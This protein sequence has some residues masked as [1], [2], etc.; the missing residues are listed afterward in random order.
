MAEMDKPRSGAGKQEIGFEQKDALELPDVKDIETE[1][2]KDSIVKKMERKQIEEK[3]APKVEA[4][5]K[6][7]PPDVPKLVFGAISK[8]IGCPAFNTDADENR[9]LARHLTTIFGKTDSRITS[10]IIILAI[11]IAK[12]VA[13]KEPIF[14]TLAKRKKDMKTAEPSDAGFAILP[15]GRRIPLHGFGEH[16]EHK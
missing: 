3:I 11:V 4:E 15:D 12:I 2:I 5:E 8:L 13:C 10:A 7:I 1:K 14:G 16:P 6:P 9:T